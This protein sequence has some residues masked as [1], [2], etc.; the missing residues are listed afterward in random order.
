MIWICVAVFGHVVDRAPTIW[1]AHLCIIHD[2]ASVY[3]I[4]RRHPADQNG[5]EPTPHQSRLFAKDA[6]LH[7]RSVS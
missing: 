5:I 2:D 4:L 3:K 6:I 1:S 7:I